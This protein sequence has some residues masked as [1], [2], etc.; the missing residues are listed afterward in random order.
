MGIFELLDEKV[1]G[2]SLQSS[3]VVGEVER[4]FDGDGAFL[5]D[6][7]VHTLIHCDYPFLLVDFPKL[8]SIVISES[9]QNLVVVGS[10]F[11]ADILGVGLEHVVHGKLL[12]FCEF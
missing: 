11:N 5:V 12:D 3:W 1:A 10:L 9:E 7:L 8:V 4:I 6:F 2:F